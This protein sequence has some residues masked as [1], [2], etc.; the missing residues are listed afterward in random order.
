LTYCVATTEEGLD[1]L[2]FLLLLLLFLLLL[3]LLLL[4]QLP[5]LPRNV[6]PHASLLYSYSAVI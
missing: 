6:V 5:T 1:I 2:L 3:F 4:L